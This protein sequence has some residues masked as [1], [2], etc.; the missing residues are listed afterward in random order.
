MTNSASG[1]LARRRGEG[2]QR[3]L[4]TLVRRHEPERGDQERLRVEAEGDL[5]RALLR[6]RW[7]KEQAGFDRHRHRPHLG[8]RP[9]RQHPLAGELVVHDDRPA[10]I[11]ETLE[12]RIVPGVDRIVGIEQAPRRHLA[13]AARGVAHLFAIAR[14]VA[15]GQRQ[16][17][18]QVMQHELVQHHDSRQLERQTEA[19]GMVRRTV[20]DLV[21]DQ[22]ETPGRAAAAPPPGDIANARR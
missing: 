18:H 16:S 22:V 13:A 9:A 8:E 19:L 1:R 11:H 10:A 12:E 17:P 5:P 14:R 7:R 20:A 2:R 4:E 3:D 6:G 15:P 21:D